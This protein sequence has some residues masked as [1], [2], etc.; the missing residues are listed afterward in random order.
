MY[1]INNAHRSTRSRQPH[2]H[3]TARCAAA[4]STSTTSLV[5]TASASEHRLFVLDDTNKHLRPR[6]DLAGYHGPSLSACG[7]PHQLAGTDYIVGIAGAYNAFGLIGSEHNGIFV[8]D[9]TNKAVIF[10]R[11]TEIS[12]GYQA[13]WDRLR[14][15]IKCSESDFINELHTNARSR[16][17]A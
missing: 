11:D 4:P 1:L 2:R 10:D 15:L 9:D 5:Q 17:A 12:S 6:R 3:E 8:L 7:T 16:I 14:D 13:Q